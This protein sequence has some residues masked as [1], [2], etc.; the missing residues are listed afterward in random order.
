MCVSVQICANVR[1]CVLMHSAFYANDV[2]HANDDRFNK[3]HSMFA[4]LTIFNA[5]M[6][7]LVVE[8]ELNA[9]SYSS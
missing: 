5:L 6:A 4:S 1:L 8:S 9:K 2:L 3:A 7:N